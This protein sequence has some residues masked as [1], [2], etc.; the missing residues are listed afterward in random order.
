MTLLQAI[1]EFNEN[2]RVTDRQRIG[3]KISLDNIHS[4]LKNKENELY[5]RE[6]FTN[7]SYDR[8][9]IIRLLTT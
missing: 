9:T 3:L 6:T 4:H 7:C 1:N 5:V 2:I 8:D